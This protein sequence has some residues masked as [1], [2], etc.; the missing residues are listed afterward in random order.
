MLKYYNITQE[1]TFRIIDAV[2]WSLIRWSS[3]PDLI[4]SEQSIPS[5]PIYEI[6]IHEFRILKSMNKKNRFQDNK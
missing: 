6:V 2:E 1:S 3:V 5:K 4:L